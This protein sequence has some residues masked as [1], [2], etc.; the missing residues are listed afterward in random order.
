M[1]QYKQTDAYKEY[2]KQY[3]KQRKQTDEYREYQKQYRLA[4]KA[5]IVDSPEIIV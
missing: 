1:K 4:Q 3:D 5:K 2:Q